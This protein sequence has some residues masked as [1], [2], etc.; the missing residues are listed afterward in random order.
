MSSELVADL[1]V[2]ELTSICNMCAWYS[3]CELR[4][5]STKII[6]QCDLF[7]PENKTGAS[8][9]STE[10]R[11]LCMN[12]FKKDTCKLQQRQDGVWHCE[13]YE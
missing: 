1:L 4:Q 12:C 11:G 7:E 9:P 5:R 8:L 2:K 3:E 10:A 13:E 6:I